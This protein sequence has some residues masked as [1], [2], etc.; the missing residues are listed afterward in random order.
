MCQHTVIAHYGPFLFVLC[1]LRPSIY[2][3]CIGLALNFCGMYGDRRRVGPP[4][5]RARARVRRLTPTDRYPRDA[6]PGPSDLK[7]SILPLSY[8]P[9]PLLTSAGTIHWDCPRRR[10]W[11]RQKHG[12]SDR[13]RQFRHKRDRPDR[14]EVVQT[15]TR[16]SRQK[17]CSIDRN[18]VVPIEARYTK[19]KRGN[20]GDSEEVLT[21]Q[22]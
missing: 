11:S 20:P 6:N 10:R 14:S 9:L 21:V 18:N 7:S 13:S 15:E 8:R 19:Q 4:T 3:I 1:A 16:Q 2:F 17:R 5:S 12:S 22:S